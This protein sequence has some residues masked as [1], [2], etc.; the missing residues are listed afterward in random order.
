LRI[1][2]TNITLA[3]RTGTE[4]YV[5]DLATALLDRGHTPIVYST[6]LGSVARELRAAL[7]LVVDDLDALVTPPDVIHG[8]HNLPTMTALLR[9]PGVPAV[10]FCHDASAWHDSP[11]GFPRILQYVAVNLPC[12]QRLVVKHAIP[13]DRVRLIL[14]FVDLERFKPRGPLPPRPE[15][16]LVF[17]NNATERTHLPAVREACARAGIAVDVIGAG[18]GKICAR[19]EEVLGDYDLVFAKGRSALEAL[20]V[21]AA[22]VLCDAAGVGP[23]VTTGELDR[24]RALGI[25]ALCQPVDPQVLALEIARYDSQD[26]TEV[27]RR[28]RATAGR[29]GAVDEILALYQEVLAEHVSRGGNDANAGWRAAAYINLLEWRLHRRYGPIKY[30]VVLPAYRRVLSVLNRGTSKRGQPGEFV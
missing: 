10:F 13:A 27:S 14:N 19:P 9:F 25:H 16:A 5:R 11:P 7:V 8:H 21:G 29:D 6:E 3:T 2:I 28:I 12:R 24:L 15:R 30:R 18:A 23:M 20:A 4:L 22:V 26:A 1:L 17:S